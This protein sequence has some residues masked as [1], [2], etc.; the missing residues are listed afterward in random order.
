MGREV[1]FMLQRWVMLGALVGPVESAGGPIKA[2]L[3]LGGSG[4]QPVK[5]NVYRFGLAWN[6]SVVDNYSGGGVIG[7]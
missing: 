7:L 3:I 5:T 4:A 1:V 6:N 2:K